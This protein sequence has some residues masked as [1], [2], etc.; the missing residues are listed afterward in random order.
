MSPMPRL[1]LVLAWHMHQPEYRNLTSGEFTQSWVYLHAIKDY[2]DMAAHLEHHPG[3]HAVVNFSP[4]LL[5]QIEDYAAQFAGGPLRDPLLRL[6]TTEDLSGL[7]QKDRQ[8][9]FEHCFRSDHDHLVSPYPHYRR[10]R[11]LFRLA[12]EPDAN[13]LAYLSGDAFADALVWYHLVWTG[14]SVRRE[15]EWIAHLLARGEGFSYADRRRIFELAGA[16]VGGLVARYRRLAERNQIE[17]ST[18]PHFHPLAPLLIAPGAAREAEPGIPLPRIDSYPGGRQR[19][20]AH[21]T[22]A[23]RS[24]TARFGAPSN[25]MWPAEGAISDAFLEILATQPLRW[26]AAGEA[27]LARSLRVVQSSTAL[28]P[29]DDYLY[30]PYRVDGSKNLICFFRDDRLSDLIGFEYSKWDGK[31]AALHFMGELRAIARRMPDGER[32]AV[33]VV[34]D[35]E[36]AWEYYAYNG[37][38]FLDELY[39]QLELASDVHPTTFNSLL[40][41]QAVRTRPLPGVIAGSWVYGTLSTWIGS[42]AKNHAWE[43]LAAA[44]HSFDLAMA[45]NRLTEAE[46][47]TAEHQLAALEGS[48]WL[49]WLGDDN[50]TQAAN[51]FD[52]LFR[53][54]LTNLYAMLKLPPPAE[55]GHAICRSPGRA[56][57]PDTMRR[58]TPEIVQSLPV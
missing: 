9:V 18:S 6:L 29:R 43:L 23:L 46:R 33:S 12:G 51:D 45:S 44:K 35:G 41:S 19:A 52:C 26:I 42:P 25:G 1:D 20:L 22:S 31:D 16:V 11:D 38:Y 54:H 34:L 5:D 40:E 58:S 37:F 36:N 57:R 49:W 50:P 3:M 14:E 48:D 21:V 47:V 13:G 56:G 27:V 28:P 10:L 8:R 32:P 15:H 7:A 2:A 55:L 39:A 53:L 17:L 30:R 4:V 24:N